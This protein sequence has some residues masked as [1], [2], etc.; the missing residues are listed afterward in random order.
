MPEGPSILILK[1]K[2]DEFIGKKVTA[3]SGNSKIDFGRAEGKKIEA[4]KTWGKHLLICFKGFTIRVH[5]MLFGTY[6]INEDKPSTPRLT[7]E[8]NDGVI[9]FYA[10]SVKLLE[11]DI[12]DHYDFTA[13]V[14]N[15]KWDAGSAK[16]KLKANPDMMACDALLEQDIFSGVGNIIKNEVLY[17]V[18][19]QPETKIRNIPTRKLS[20]LIKE[21]R[22]YSFDF[23][24][25]K[26]QNVLKKNWLAHTK[27]VCKR[28]DLPMIKKVTGKKKRRSFFCTNCQELYE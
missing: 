27:K 12:N 17:R 26:K 16:A 10:C 7:L 9:H 2:L 5:L 28:C 22:N 15:D 3:V 25:W 6:R 8:F 14:M 4:I 23:L 24:K 13:D 18:H 19:V 1:E 21:A 20:E 11:G